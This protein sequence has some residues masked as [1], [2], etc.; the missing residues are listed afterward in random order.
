[1]EHIVMMRR[2]WIFLI[3][4]LAA[5][6]AADAQTMRLEFTSDDFVVTPVFNDVA[7]F[8]FDIEINAPLAPGVYTNPDIISVLYRVSGEL[9]NTP[10]NFPAFALQRDIT[11][12]E[13]YAQGSSLV[14]EVRAGAVLD[15]GVQIAELAG[16]G[17]VF[18]FN[19]KEIG[20]GRFHPAL[21][22]FNAD[23]TGMIQNSDNV[24][25]ENPFQQVDFGEEYITDLAFDGGNLTLLTAVAAEPDPPVR[26][27][28]GGTIS[29]QLLVLLMLLTL[30]ARRLRAVLNPFAP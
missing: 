29:L 6:S 21:L 2:A 13:F 7:Q 24:I 4:S 9:M 19:G 10:S 22:E 8:S 1:M 5:F 15:D 11:G 27:S 25:T 28:G 3:F 23:G 26:R 12:D 14:F 16:G 20:N 18:T 30:G 17:I